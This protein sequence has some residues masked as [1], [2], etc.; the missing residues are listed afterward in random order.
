MVYI[1]PPDALN[2][3]FT[4]YFVAVIRFLVVYFTQENVQ[5]TFVNIG[6]E[7]SDNMASRFL[8]EKLCRRMGRRVLCNKP[9]EKLIFL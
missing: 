1:Y 5:V 6:K 7:V 4:V 2:V 9:E 3:T 8:V